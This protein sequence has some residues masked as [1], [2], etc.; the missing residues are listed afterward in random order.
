MSAAEQSTTVTTCCRIRKVSGWSA[1]LP[2]HPKGLTSTWMQQAVWDTVSVINLS[3]TH[4]QPTKAAYAKLAT[5]LQQHAAKEWKCQRQK[6]HTRGQ[7]SLPPHPQACRS[8]RCRDTTIRHNNTV[9]THTHAAPQMTLI[10]LTGSPNATRAHTQEPPV[11]LWQGMA[12]P[13]KASHDR[14]S[15]AEHMDM[16]LHRCLTGVA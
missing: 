9:Q 7:G 10:A 14:I 6:V 15:T 12:S 5:M 3:S 1:Q 16:G 2:N 13:E 4:V 11:P 8:S